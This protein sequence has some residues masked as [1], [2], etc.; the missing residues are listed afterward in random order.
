MTPAIH[1]SILI[2]DDDPRIRASVPGALKSENLDVRTAEDAER[3][4]S[5]LGERPADVVLS[6]IR[7]PGMDGLELLRLLRQRAPN[8]AVILM[9]AYD[10]L[11]TVASAMREGAVDFLVKPLELQHLRSVIRRVFEDL[12]ARAQRAEPS[13]PEE[14]EGLAEALVGH[15][16]RMIEIFKLVG[17]L[18]ASRTNVVIRGA[19]GTGKELIARAIH[20]A[21]PYADRPFVAVNC[22]ALPSTLLES[23]LFGHMKGSFTGASSDRRGR[24]ALA[25]KGTIFL[26]EI[27]DTSVDFQAKL[28]RVLQEH[29]YYP[30]GAERPE[31]MEARVIAATHRNLEQLVERAEF[32]EDLYY[33]LRVVEIVV[34]P[35]RER[36]GD[37]PTLAEHLVRKVSLAAD[38]PVPMLAP[39]AMDVLISHTWPGNVRELENCLTRAVV[40]ATGD[41]IRPEHLELAPRED[42]GELGTLE[43]AE[44]DHVTR[45]LTATQGHKSRAAEILGISR[46]RLDRLIEKYRLGGLVR[47][48]RT[49]EETDTKRDEP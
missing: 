32:R 49:G 42:V 7:M 13:E 27:G 23:E 28:L 17:Q 24:F 43:T 14:P 38:R 35:L 15:D 1:N 12:E 2:V 33:R 5:L 44:R 11:P 48:R 4:L 20:R 34:P 29:E 8:V 41:V 18:S 22:T 3:A 36:P 10:D 37:I 30:V 25:E 46:P 47:T 16:P 9:T 21:S 40:L 31:R 26:D 45:V 19:S 6:D 39:E